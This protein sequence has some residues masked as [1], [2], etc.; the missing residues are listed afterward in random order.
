M[1]TARL[2]YFLHG[3]NQ[4]SCR[5]RTAEPQLPA[6]PHF[7]SPGKLKASTE[8]SHQLTFRK[9]SASFAQPLRHNRKLTKLVLLLL[10]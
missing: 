10:Q 9:I 7:E 2:N 5:H 3:F 6:D 1:L 8:N 4:N